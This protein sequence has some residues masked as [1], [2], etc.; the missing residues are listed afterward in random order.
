MKSK[1][2]LSL[3]VVIGAVGC[4]SSKPDD[5]TLM[6]LMFLPSSSI[7]AEGLCMDIISASQT[8]VNETCSYSSIGI[9]IYQNEA[10]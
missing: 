3:L 2:L 1:L 5:F 8:M 9:S 7:D 6:A 10:T 4:A